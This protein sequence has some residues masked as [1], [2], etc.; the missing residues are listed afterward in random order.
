MEDRLSNGHVSPGTIP[1]TPLPHYFTSLD[2]KV[3]RNGSYPLLIHNYIVGGQYKGRN[4]VERYFQKLKYY[5]RIAT[6]YDKLACV[7]QAFIYIASV[8]IKI[9]NQTRESTLKTMCAIN[10]KKFIGRFFNTP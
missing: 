1:S 7:Y 5:R 6:R 10:V 4:V 8:L 2:N 9:G 3:V